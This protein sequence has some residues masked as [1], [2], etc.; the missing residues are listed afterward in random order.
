MVDNKRTSISESILSYVRVDAD[1]VQSHAVHAHARCCPLK[2]PS[3]LH[4]GPDSVTV[5]I[6]IRLD[7]GKLDLISVVTFSIRWLAGMQR[8]T[9]SVANIFRCTQIC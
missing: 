8:Y 9:P 1:F 2:I 3:Q 6:P 5:S 7:C 4:S